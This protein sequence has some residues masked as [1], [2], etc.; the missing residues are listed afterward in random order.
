M[1]YPMTYDRLIA[2]NNLTGDYDGGQDGQPQFGGIRGDL[3]R[4]EHDSRD[5]A[6]LEAYAALV[7]ITPNQAKRLLDAFFKGDA[8]YD[9]SML[10]VSDAAAPHA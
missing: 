10:P 5:A 2:R 4:L 8:L 3:R 7:N 1:G 6:H 9:A